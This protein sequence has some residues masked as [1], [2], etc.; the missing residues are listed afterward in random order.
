MPPDGCNLSAESP[1]T[2][3]DSFVSQSFN[4]W[5]LNIN[6]STHSYYQIQIGFDTFKAR[7]SNVAGYTII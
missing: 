4:H 3:E 6:L 1:V 5:W 2:L 7:F